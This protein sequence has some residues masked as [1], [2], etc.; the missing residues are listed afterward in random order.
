[1]ANVWTMMAGLLQAP[2]PSDLDLLAL[3]LGHPEVLADAAPPPCCELHLPPPAVYTS[4]VLLSSD[5][6]HS[7]WWR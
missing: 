3:W 5:L 6:F 4:P 1:M 7:H 2:V